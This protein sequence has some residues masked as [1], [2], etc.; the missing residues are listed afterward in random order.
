MSNGI[1]ILNI[2]KYKGHF[3]AE[4]ADGRYVIDNGSMELAVCKRTG[5]GLKV[6]ETGIVGGRMMRT[7]DDFRWC[8]EHARY[9]VKTRVSYDISFSPTTNIE[10]EVADPLNPTDEEIDDMVEKAR[11]NIL[12]SGDDYISADNL[13]SIAIYDKEKGT[14]TPILKNGASCPAVGNPFGIPDLTPML[15]AVSD[16]VRENQGKKG[17][18]NTTD[19]AGDC[20]YG[21]RFQADFC[22]TAVKEHLVVAVAYMDNELCV[23]LKDNMVDP[24]GYPVEVSD[25]TIKENLD[26]F[27]SVRFS[28]IMYIQTIFNIAEF[29]TQYVD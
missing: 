2:T 29:I 8:V 14:V 7:E 9:G 11:E 28:D 26:K 20:I 23:L 27:E 18:I 16:F 19:D 17:F 1:K 5:P 25:A 21:Y 13:E 12:A 10:A 6:V 22:E 3:C 24:N 4:L 15:N